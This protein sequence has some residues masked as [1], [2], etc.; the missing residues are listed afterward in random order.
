MTHSKHHHSTT[1]PEDANAGAY[2]HMASWAIKHHDAAKAEDALSHAETRLLTR[3][4]PQ[5]SA[6][7]TD[8]APAIASIEHARS[9]VKSGNFTQASADTQTAMQQAHD[10]M[11]TNASAT[12]P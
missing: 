2:L 7:S 12:T 8:D 5:S 6:A 4:V 10:S 9:E 1:L 3:A 11:V